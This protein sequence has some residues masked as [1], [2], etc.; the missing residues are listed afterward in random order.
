MTE[1]IK[2]S[3]QDLK[4][5]ILKSLY[6]T[7]PLKDILVLK[8]GNALSIVHERIERESTDLDFSLLSSSYTDSEIRDMIKAVLGT[9]LQM[10]DLEVIDYEFRR[11]PSFEGEDKFPWWGGFKIAFKIVRRPT[12]ETSGISANLKRL[13][14]A[15][16]PADLNFKRT[17]S[18]DLSFQEFCD[19]ATKYIVRD[20]EVFAYTEEMC[21]LE[22][23][24][25]I[26]QQHPE[27]CNTLG[28]FPKERARDF[29]DILKVLDGSGTDLTLPENKELCTRIFEAKKCPLEL[30]GRISET[31]EIHEQGATSLQSFLAVDSDFNLMFERVVEL[32]RSLESSWKK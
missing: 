10:H 5:I 13:R 22:K 2:Y 25:A 6:A 23:L 16:I 15:S 31:R 17:F 3:P 29:Y 19:Q 1:E 14:K 4:R 28:K 26:C 21:V 24:R 12:P 11:V 32:G 7:P 18:I 27:Y 20:F 9:H 30:L 8:G